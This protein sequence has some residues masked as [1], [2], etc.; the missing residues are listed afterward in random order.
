M[1]YLILSD[2]HANW[3]ALEAVLADAQGR[4]DE[5]LCLGDLVGYCADPNRVTGWVRENVRSVVRGNHD[6]A[7]AGLEDLEWFN[8]I[9]K[10]AAE[11]T[12]RAL[13]PANLEYLRAL[14]RGPLCIDSFQIVHGSPLDE[15]DYVV[16]AFDAGQLCGYLQTPV[17]FFGHTHLQGGFLCHRNGVKRIERPAR[18][19]H[20]RALDLEPNIVYLL[21]PG[22]VGQPRDGDARAA[23]AI[24]DRD[25]RYVEY[26]RVQYDIAACQ[27]KILAAGLPPLLAYRLEAGT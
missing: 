24:Y 11:W 4:Y 3:E 9:A 20:V 17:S 13:T 2:L 6:K 10:Q 19:T 25:A 26:R 21:N 8:P 23:Y 14:P 1:R 18:D 5:P 22:S 7:C 15:D 12:M 27:S 16:S